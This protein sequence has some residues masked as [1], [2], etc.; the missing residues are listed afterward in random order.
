MR[1]CVYVCARVHVA[2]NV[3]QGVCVCAHTCV[4][5]CVAA[6]FP[7]CCVCPGPCLAPS[8]WASP[9][10]RWHPLLRVDVGALCTAAVALLKDRKSG[11]KQMV[12]L[13][14]RYRGD[15]QTWPWHHHGIPWLMQC[16]RVPGDLRHRVHTR[17]AMQQVPGNVCWSWHTAAGN[18]PLHTMMV[19]GYFLS[20]CILAAAWLLLW[21][22]RRGEHPYLR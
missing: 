7:V 17:C 9:D 14:I 11:P 21:L 19:L 8:V 13:L 20:A 4:C 5:M 3:Q 2:R 16:D 12:Q 18:I 15:A 1:A 22:L 10:W 6:H